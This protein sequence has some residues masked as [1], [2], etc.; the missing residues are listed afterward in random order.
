MDDYDRVSGDQA[1]ATTALN[2]VNAGDKV[3]YGDWKKLVICWFFGAGLFVVKNPYA[4]AASGEETA[5]FTAF[6]DAG[7][8]QPQAM[9]CSTD[10][11]AQ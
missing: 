1:L 7:L 2:S 10:S 4:K 8:V 5:T 11:G 6:V 3:I 9:V